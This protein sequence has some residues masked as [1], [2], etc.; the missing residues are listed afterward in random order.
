MT[1]H[2]ARFAQPFFVLRDSRS[3]SHLMFFGVARKKGMTRIVAFLSKKD[4]EDVGLALEDQLILKG[5]FPLPGDP[6]VLSNLRRGCTGSHKALGVLEVWPVGQT[7]CLPAE[8][9]G[10]AHVVFNM[11]LL[12]LEDVDMTCDAFSFSSKMVGFDR[13][14]TVGE[15]VANAKKSFALTLTL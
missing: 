7:R 9:G 5:K 3:E 15:M 10:S 12:L 1:S 6:K 4:A 13:S 11:D 2:A 8:V 14:H